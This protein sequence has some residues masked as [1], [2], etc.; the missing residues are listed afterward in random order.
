LTAGVTWRNLITEPVSRASIVPVGHKHRENEEEEMNFVAKKEKD[1][2]IVSITGRMD[3]VTTP[4]TEGKL[5][6][7]IVAGERKL[8]ID[9][10]GLDY[11]SSAGLR[12]VLATAKK[13]RRNTEIWFLPASRDM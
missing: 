2:T 6:E 11:I 9:F 8:V 12:G 10:Q 7:L 4:E 3:A 1:I 5:T 13:L